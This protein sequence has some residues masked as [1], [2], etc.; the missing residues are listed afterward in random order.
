MLCAR[1]ERSLPVAHVL[2]HPGERTPVA[3]LGPGPWPDDAAPTTHERVDMGS[4]GDP[5]Q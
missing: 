4:E 5:R 1:K 2:E 3:E